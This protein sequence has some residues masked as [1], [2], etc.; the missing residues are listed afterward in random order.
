MAND[1]KIDAREKKI[2]EQHVAN[3]ERAISGPHLYPV[4]A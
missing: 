4:L 1:Q 2:F 3:G